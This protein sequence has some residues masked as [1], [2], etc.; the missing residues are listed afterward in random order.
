MAANIAEQA[1]RY[2]YLFI[3][4]E[5]GTFSDK[6]MSA[7]GEAGCEVTIHDETADLRQDVL[8]TC[9]EDYAVG[10]DF[11][12]QPPEIGTDTLDI[13]IIDQ[14]SGSKDF[15]DDAPVFGAEETLQF[16]R[17]ELLAR[18]N[19]PKIAARD[20]YTG[21]QQNHV[22]DA[23][24][25]LRADGHN[26]ER[27]FISAGFGLVAED[28]G[29]PPYE[30]TFSSMNVGE[31][32]ERSAKLQISE[33]LQD[34][35]DESDYDI[36][37]FALGS[38]YY[39]SVDIDEMVQN[40]RS[41]RIGVVFNREVVEDQFDNIESVPARTEDAKRHSTIVIGLKGLYLENFAKY[42]AEVDTVSPG[43]IEK[44]CRRIETEPEQP[45]FEEY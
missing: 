44:L 34:V 27:H 23:V 10:D 4:T 41:D 16:S 37:F 28:D 29:L 45:T 20:L 1:A 24:R 35:L 18:D 5:D 12:P 17:K 42:V 15:P 13:L 30:V 33:S 21:R 26:V 43:M 3:Q 11:L 39:T 14:C 32:R 8:E 40:V 25:R 19:V 36:V 6:I 7:V 31:I 9:G 22:R 38:D 2:E